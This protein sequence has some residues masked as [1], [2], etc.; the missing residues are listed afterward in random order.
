MSYRFRCRG[1]DEKGEEEK[2]G[3]ETETIIAGE[4]GVDE[5]R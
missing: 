4:K 1:T 5:N 2:K 3:G